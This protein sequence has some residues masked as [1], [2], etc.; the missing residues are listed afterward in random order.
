MT[1]SNNWK[2]WIDKENGLVIREING[3]MIIDY[4]YKF[5]T[6]TDENVAKPDISDCKIIDNTQ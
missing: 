2:L 6:V 3:N 4:M 1:T 5:N